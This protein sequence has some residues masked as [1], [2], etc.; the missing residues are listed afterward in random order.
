MTDALLTLEDGIR[1]T[2]DQ[3]R[4]LKSEGR[5]DTADLDVTPPPVVVA[6]E[7]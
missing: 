4:K 2:L 7:T 6:N 5:L 1:R 3:F